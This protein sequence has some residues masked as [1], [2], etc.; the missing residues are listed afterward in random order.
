MAEPQV[1]TR[2]NEGAKE[3]EEVEDDTGNM[4]SLREPR[5]A[6]CGR[7]LTVLGHSLHL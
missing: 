2:R 7:A 3:K 4:C 1:I 6:H 5:P